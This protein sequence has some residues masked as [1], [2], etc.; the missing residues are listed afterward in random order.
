MNLAEMRDY[1]KEFSG[2]DNL[3]NARIDNMLNRAITFLSP[4]VVGHF[5]ESYV[6]TG[7]KAGQNILD[8][9]EDMNSVRKIWYI[10]DNG[11][12]IPLESYL[13]LED[14]LEENP[15]QTNSGIPA[16]WV[17]LPPMALASAK[18]VYTNFKKGET[19][20][21]TQFDGKSRLVLLF[22]A[23]PMSDI[24]LRLLGRRRINILKS[25][26]DFNILTQ[27]EPFLLA[28]TT[29]YFLEFYMRQ[30]NEAGAIM[31][32][33][34]EQLASLDTTSIEAEAEQLGDQVYG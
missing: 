11:T 21:S 8:V 24:S 28:L 5:G 6:L 17:K 22:S 18:N 31:S 30:Y 23:T 34:R 12:Y 19:Y 25:D 10:D 32:Q 7:I 13:T 33:V 4:K 1:F 26:D 27:Q 14:F 15:N 9:T 20:T 16:E 29:L 2:R 3:S